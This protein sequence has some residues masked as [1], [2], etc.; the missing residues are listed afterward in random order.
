MIIIFP[1]GARNFGLNM[2]FMEFYDNRPE[3]H[4]YEFSQNILFCV[5]AS[6]PQ[7]SYSGETNNITPLAFYEDIAHMF[8]NYHKARMSLIIDCSSHFINELND[9]D[10]LGNMILSQANNY[11]DSSIKVSTNYAYD[12]FHSKYPNCRMIASAHYEDN[13][14]DREFFLKEKW[15][16][17]ENKNVKSPRCAR[18]VN[19]IC[20]QCSQEQILQCQQSEDLN[21]TIFSIE[22]MYETCANLKTNV[23]IFSSEHDDI[24]ELSGKGYK[25]FVLPNYH[26]FPLIQAKE[27]VKALIKPEY[28]EE[29]LEWIMLS[30]K[31]S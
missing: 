31:R 4:L 21:S 23:H 9:Y 18:R 16:N 28:R 24:Q 15:G 19:C 27:Y 30:L 6:F 11:G 3:T 22:S 12:Y 25:Y 13:P 26:T 2:T 7:V 8:S 10:I 20:D 14:G 1:D 5:E 29:A 17:I